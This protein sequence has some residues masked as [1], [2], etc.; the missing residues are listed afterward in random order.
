[1][2]FK[3]ILV[4]ENVPVIVGAMQNKSARVEVLELCLA[5]VI[6]IL[7][8]E[9]GHYMLSVEGASDLLVIEMSHST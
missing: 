4:K 3:F 6:V 1:M 9:Q 8:S 5:T 2:S 7:E